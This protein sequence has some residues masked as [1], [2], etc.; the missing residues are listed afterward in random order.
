VPRVHH[1]LVGGGHRQPQLAGGLAVSSRDQVSP[2]QAVLADGS[3]Q[4]ATVLPS[5]QAAGSAPAVSAAAGACSAA[6][7]ASAA[8]VGIVPA[9]LM[10]MDAVLSAMATSPLGLMCVDEY[11]SQ[12]VSINV[13][14][15]RAG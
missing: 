10:A 4:A 6:T 1:G 11:L 13:N 14:A 3:Q 5:Q 15:L 2:Q 8:W 7:I 9:G 12:I